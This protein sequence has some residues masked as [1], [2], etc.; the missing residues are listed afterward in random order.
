MAKDPNV[1]Y[2]RSRKNPHQHVITYTDPE[3]GETVVHVAD[4][5]KGFIKTFQQ[6]E[7][8]HLHDSRENAP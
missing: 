4:L 1:N 8:P 3:T 7:K 2:Y 6:E 5:A